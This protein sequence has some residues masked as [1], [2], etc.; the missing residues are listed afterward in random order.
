MDDLDELEASY[1]RK[2]EAVLSH[3]ETFTAEMFGPRCDDFEPDCCVCKMWKL[4]DE[5]FQ[6]TAEK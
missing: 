2:T 6:L 1:N 3:L 4:N 5:L